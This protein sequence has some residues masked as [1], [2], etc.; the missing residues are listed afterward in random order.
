M[1]GDLQ[2]GCLVA[3]GDWRELGCHGDAEHMAGGWQG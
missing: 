1:G 2:L 3:C